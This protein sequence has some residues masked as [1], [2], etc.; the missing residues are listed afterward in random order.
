[1]EGLL[2]EVRAFRRFVQRA[3]LADL[4]LQLDAKA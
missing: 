2:A 4:N 1:M 3:R